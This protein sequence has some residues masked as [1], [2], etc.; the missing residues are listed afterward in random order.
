MMEQA[1]EDLFIASITIGEIWRDIL[2]LPAGRRRR[3]LESWFSAPSGPQGAFEG[4]ILPFDRKAGLVWGRLMA[5]G[6]RIG[7]PRSATDMILAAIAE[8]NDCIL[9][10]GNEKHFEG[11]KFVNS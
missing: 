3:L 10:T 11:L 6:T 8:A 5:D 4:R 7:R 9:V 1:S 2:E